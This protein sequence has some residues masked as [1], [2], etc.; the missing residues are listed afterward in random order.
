MIMSDR[1]SPPPAKKRRAANF[2]D[3]Q[4]MVLIQEVADR[5][6]V[7][8]GPLTSVVTNRT[9]DMAWRAVTEAVNAFSRVPREVAEIKKKWFSFKSEVKGKAARA[10]S[11]RIK[12]GKSSLLSLILFIY[13]VLYQ[14]RLRISLCIAFQSLCVLVNSLGG[15]FNWNYFYN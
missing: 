8:L 6:T 12:T 9:K 4:L 10:R 15:N 14:R 11:A 5:K 3:E 7:I 2:T 13:K 1:Q